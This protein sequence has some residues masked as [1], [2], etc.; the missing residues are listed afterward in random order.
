MLKA[1]Q[2]V[3]V[4]DGDNPDTMTEP[5][6]PDN[7][8]VPPHPPETAVPNATRLV[9]V[10]QSPYIDTFHNHHHARIIID[11]GATCNLIHLSAI[12]RFRAKVTTSSQSAHQ[13]DGSSPMKVVGEARLFF[14][15]DTHTFQFEGLVVE[16]L[17]VD[18][19]AGTPFMS[20]NDIAVRPARRQVI[21][22]DG[23]TFTYGSAPVP[24]NNTVRRATVLRAPSSPTT[25]WPGEFLEINLPP[26]LP[27]D[28]DYIVE[29]R[30]D[31][32]SIRKCS[33]SEMWPLPSVL[34]SVA[35]RIRI[36]NLSAEPHTLKRHEHFCQVDPLSTPCCDSPVPAPGPSSPVYDV[37]ATKHSS[38]TKHSDA[39]RLDP[40]NLLPPSIQSQFRELLTRYDRVFD[41]AITGYNGAVGPF[42]ARVNM[43]PVEPPQRKGRLPLYGRDKLTELQQKFDELENLGVFQRPEDLGITV[44]YLNPSFLVK[45]PNGGYRLVTAFTDV[46]RYS[47]PQPSLMPDVDS[48][49]RHIAQWKYLI[50]TDLTSAFYQIPLARESMKYCGVATPYRGVRVY[51]RTAMGMPGSETALEELMCRV[52]GDLLTAGVV[53]KI[54]DDLYCGGNTPEELLLNWSLVLQALHKSGPHLSASKTV[55]SPLSTTVLGWVWS[56]GNLKASPHR[57]STLASCDPQKKVGGMKSFIGAYK[58]LARVIPHCLSLLSPLDDAIA[59][60]TSQED[61][62]WTDDLQAAFVHAQRALNTNR[63]ITLPQPD[64][65]LWIVTDGAVRKPGIAATLYT[66][67]KEKLAVAG[68][69]SAK[70]HS[71]QLAWL[72]CE[73]EALAIAAAI[74]H[75]SPY[76]IQSR[77]NAS[78]LTDNK[79]CVQAFNKLCRGE[80]SASPRVSTFLAT[81][82]RFQVSIQHV[83]GA[84]ILP[85]DFASRN[86]P[87]CTDIACQICNFVKQTEE[88]IVRRAS[89]DDILS[90]RVK[91][92]FTSRAAWLSLQSECPDLRR[93]HAHL[94]QGTRPS[95]K[96]TNVRDVK[97]YLNVTT[98]SADGLLIVKRNDPLCPTREC[99]VVPRQVLDGLLTAL[100]LQLSHPTAYQLKKV[101]SRYFYALDIEKAVDNVTTGCHTCAALKHVP[102]IATEQTTTDPPSAVGATFAADIMKR[103]R[104]LILV[105]RECVS[106]YTVSVLVKDERS[107]TL[108]DALI[109]LCAELCPLDGPSALI[110]TDPAP[111][112]KSLVN[113]ELL[114]RHRI[115]LE[116]GR[117]KNPN[118]NPVAE[119]AIQELE[120]ELLRQDPHGEPISPTLLAV[121]T[122]RLN[123]RI[124]SRGLSAREIWTHRDQFTNKQIPVADQT[125]IL[126]QHAGRLENHPYSERSKAPIGS[127][128]TP[129]SIDIGDLVYLYADRTKHHSRDRY[130]VT[131]VES[132]W[133]H[134]RKFVGS[135]LRQSPYRVKKS[136]CF[137]VPSSLPTQHRPPAG[138]Y[139]PDSSE[140]EEYPQAQSTAAGPGPPRIPEEIAAI[141][142]SSSESQHQARA[143]LPTEMEAA[144]SPRG[145]PPRARHPPQWLGDFVTDF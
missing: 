77:H 107:A 1:R 4:L 22:G 81:V 125:L 47:K 85:S 48:T 123:T 27:A 120:E 130:L 74:K 95:K 124:R 94:T 23:S 58:V 109:Q 17:D 110:R 20:V 132:D 102:N 14:T 60:R 50:A 82:S 32:P 18:I 118:K 139:S 33:T 88:S 143:N 2:I 129:P 64:D 28:S 117:A 93:T 69:Y 75:F 61:I 136:D 3:A 86:P 71:H 72:P 79:P 38:V 6:P 12:R 49:L 116:L 105:V 66:M 24:H 142:P 46:G 68:F 53:A 31:S 141:P 65:Q 106:S 144:S 92:P 104:Q 34:A 137:K 122:A 84:A 25:I 89:T 115:M 45:K 111:A 40:D 37:R 83:A 63:A 13:A 16:D 134:L 121:A 7:E 114:G 138:S 112:F 26:D 43:G 113:D 8:G 97:R 15:R 62:L 9:Q 56:Q 51:T 126:Q 5:D 41:P 131:S 36:P 76:L 128:P 90:G 119:R 21:L 101:V 127:I 70:L 54:A 52:L 80:F 30:L 108:R 73:V 133:C 44:E 145:R 96:T 99:I 98:I 57:V 19:L 100:H 39:V 29:P 135:Q 55:I 103:A 87:D 35:G 140:D 42:Q 91:P 10:R 59:G 78:V 67:R 11:S